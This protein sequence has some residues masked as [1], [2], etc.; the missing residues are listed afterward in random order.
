MSKSFEK[1]R[2]LLEEM[3]QLNQADLDFGIYRI[4]NYKRREIEKFLDEDLL[5]QVRGELEKY[6][7]VKQESLIEEMDDLKKT[8]DTTGV[9]Y[10]QS[11]K[12]V[13]LKSQIENGLSVEQAESEVYSHL[14]NFFGRYYDNGDFISARRYK[15]GVYAIPYEGEEVKLH[16]AN[17]DQYYIKT[18]EYFRD[19]SFK[20]PCGKIVHFKLVEADT[21]KDNN[22]APKDKERRFVIYKEEPFKIEDGELY[23]HFEYKVDSKKQDKLIA[24]ALDLIKTHI[25]VSSDYAPFIEIFTQRPTEKNPNRTLIEKHLNDYTA[26]NTFD[27]FIHKDL[28]G[29]LR[30]ELDFYLKNEVMFLDDL[31]TENER[32]VEEYITKIKVIKSIGHKII[33]FLA[34]IEDFQKKL[35]LK[36]K[37]IVQ[38]DYCI[39]LDKVDESFYPEIIDNGKQIEEWKKL[40]AIDEIEGY[41]EPLTIKFLKENPYLVLDTAFYDEN[42]KE[43]LIESIDNI[44]EKTDGLLIHSENFQALNLLQERY[45]D[46]VD[47]IFIDPPYNTGDGSQVQIS[48]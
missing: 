20:L 29:F 4:M 10:E 1:L 46:K 47:N 39:T 26:R 35:W 38:T 27:Y 2:K 33:E 13:A 5:P 42:F 3:F 6:I 22:K 14:A 30:R 31:N 8:L 36:K 41:I 9:V 37:F 24:E 45:K 28:G 21:E 16:W 40:F 43:K 7:S 25:K 23:I 19:Y 44:D 34:Q 17:A 32:R 15:E 11:A 12:Y 48:V 18:T